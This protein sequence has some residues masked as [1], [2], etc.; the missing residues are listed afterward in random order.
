MHLLKTTAP[1]VCAGKAARHHRVVVFQN[2]YCR[3]RC[4]LAYT[5]PGKDALIFLRRSIKG[6]FILPRGPVNY[7][8]VHALQADSSNAD[9]SPHG[10]GQLHVCACFTGRFIKGGFILPRGPVNYMFVHALQADSSKADL[11]P[12]GP[13]QLRI[14]PPHWPGLLRICG[15]CTRRCLKG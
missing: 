1:S 8:F 15:C 7:M 12:H 4:L 11:S 9:L 3:A 5:L 2:V 14:Y 10:P 13:G 6:G